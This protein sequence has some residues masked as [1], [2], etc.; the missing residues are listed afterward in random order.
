MPA[1]FINNSCLESLRAANPG[2][3]FLGYRELA[4]AISS[5]PASLR[6]MISRREIE[7]D[8]IKV[9]RRRLF[10]VEAIAKFIDSRRG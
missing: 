5:S 7:I 1:S 3:A 6:S 9:G 4:N 2:K 10:S 8:S